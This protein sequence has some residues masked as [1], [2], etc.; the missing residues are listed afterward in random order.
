MAS[1]PKT[2]AILLLIGGIIILIGGILSLYSGATFSSLPS[3]YTI[4]GVTLSTG[5][6]TGAVGTFIVISGAIALVCAIV[7]MLSG[8]MVYKK[9]SKIKTWG[10]LGLVFAIISLANLGGYIIGFVLA[11]VGA[12]LALTYKG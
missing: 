8:I 4:N 2:A 11:L 6:I 10:V 7:I 12:I 3:S 1:K 5:A 9:A